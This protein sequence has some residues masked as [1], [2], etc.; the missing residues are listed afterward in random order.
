M[1]QHNCVIMVTVLWIYIPADQCSIT[2][3]APHGH[4]L[5]QKFLFEAEI[6]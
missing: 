1:K 2:A 3:V 5:M 4:C 6:N